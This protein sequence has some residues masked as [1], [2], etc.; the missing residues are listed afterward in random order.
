M[1]Y[2]FIAVPMESSLAC[3]VLLMTTL[4]THPFDTSAG[5]IFTFSYASVNILS[6]VQHKTV[7]QI[8]SLTV[9]G[10]SLLAYVDLP[11][12]EF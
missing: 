4:T 7:D 1:N 6:R 9:N 2:L 3:Y 10:T 12:S 5:E 11:E 8:T